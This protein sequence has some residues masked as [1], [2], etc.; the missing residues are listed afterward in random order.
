MG[1]L[2]YRLM[3]MRTFSVALI[4]FTCLAQTA[5]EPAFEAASIK[6]ATAESRRTPG[7]RIQTYPGSLVTHGL[8]LRACLG[9]AYGPTVQLVAPDW[10]STVALDINAKAATP[11]GDKELYRMLRTLLETRMG[12]KAH[13]EK[14]EMEVYALVVAKGGPKFKASETEGPLQVGQDKGVSVIQHAS[15]GEFAAQL[16]DNVFDRPVIDATGLTGRYDIRFDMR[17]VLASQGPNKPDR[18]DL[19]TAVMDA[20]Q[21]Q[22]GLK[23]ESRKALLDVVVIDHIEK[24][25]TEN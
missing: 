9:W 6:L 12:L 19:A 10:T 14:R 18:A 8:S 25:P 20:I 21:E 24:T 15:L 1:I 4:A 5:Q 13:T 16:S 2:F 11:A 17:S 3:H 7:R 23:V 22:M